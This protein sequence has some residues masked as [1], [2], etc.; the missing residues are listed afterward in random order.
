MEFIRF[1][2][3]LLPP[4]GPVHVGYTDRGI[5]FLTTTAAD[6]QAFAAQVRGRYGCGVWRDDACRERWLAH[7]QD[8]L[9]GRLQTPDLD[10]ARVSPFDRRVMERCMAIPR[11]SVATYRE[12]AEAAGSAGASRAV[13]GVMRRNPVP[14]LV[15]CHRVVASTGVIGNYSMGGP[16]IKRLLLE[17]EG[18]D[19]PGLK[20][21]VRTRRVAAR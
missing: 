7:L 10:L 20:D 18:V 5:C 9:A 1:T 15:P 16:E 3:L 13:G 17:W 19:L 8:W 14:L 6:D 21:Q 4:L 11:G 2:T 12:L